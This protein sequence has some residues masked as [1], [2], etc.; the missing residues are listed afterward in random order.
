[1]GKAFF[2]ATKDATLA[3]SSKNFS[4]LISATP[5]AFNL[6]AAQATSYAS[7]DAAWQAAYVA[8]SVVASRTK[9]LVVA[10]NAARDNMKLAASALA[11]YV[12]ASAAV[13]DMQLTQ[14]GLSVRATPQPAREPGMPRDF[15]AIVSVTGALGLKWKCANPSGTAGVMYQIFRRAGETGPFTYVGGTGEKKFTDGTI[16]AGATQ[17]TYQVQAVRSTAAGV[18]AEFTVKLGASANGTLA[19]T[20]ATVK[21]AA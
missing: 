5:T 3:A 10:K 1:M 21:L 13:S 2:N 15:V 11:K 16:P 7:V 17:V 18:W 4:T 9:A 14:L 8:A 12:Y 19:T 20:S 6:S